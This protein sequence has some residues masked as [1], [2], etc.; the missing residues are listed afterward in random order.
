MPRAPWK[1]SRRRPPAGLPCTCPALAPALASFLFF[2][3]LGSFLPLGIR[4]P[5]SSVIHFKERDP[6]HRLFHLYT[7]LSL[8]LGS[9]PNNKH[10]LLTLPVI[11]HSYSSLYLGTFSFFLLDQKSIATSSPFLTFSY[12]DFNF[13]TIRS[14]HLPLHDIPPSTNQAHRLR[15]RFIRLPTSPPSSFLPLA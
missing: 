2:P 1:Q 7:L 10:A 5:T 8:C 4:K 11:P 14:A 13:V 15:I 3:L 6:H 9:S 12:R